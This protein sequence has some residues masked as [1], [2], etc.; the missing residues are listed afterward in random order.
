M[1]SAVLALP[2]LAYILFPARNQVETG[3]ADAGDINDFPLD[4]PHEVIFQRRR[5]DGWKLSV[6][7][8]TAW[9]LRTDA[10]VV[11]LIGHDA[12]RTRKRD[13]PYSR[14]TG[15]RPGFGKMRST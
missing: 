13:L 9:V 14:R 11:A 8:A 10:G 5:Q 3:W 15:T 1:I 12:S 4:Q 2:A 7:R 6:E